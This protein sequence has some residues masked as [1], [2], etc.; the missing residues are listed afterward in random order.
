METTETTR[1][2]HRQTQTEMG[3]PPPCFF[4]WS[5]FVCVCLWLLLRVFEAKNA[6]VIQNSRYLASYDSRPPVVCMDEPPIQL[7]KE[8]RVPVPATREH[9]RRVD[10]EYERAGTASIFMFCEPL[11]GWRQVSVR[12]W[13][14]GGRRW[15]GRGQWRDGWKGARRQRRR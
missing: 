13:G 9:P 11:S 7:L 14:G 8:T 4:R 6:H 5:V 3:L 2:S 15:M 1:R 10:D 12:E